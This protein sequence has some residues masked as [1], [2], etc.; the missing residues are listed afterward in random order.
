M[1]LKPRYEEGK[2]MLHLAGRFDAYQAPAVAEWLDD[3]MK[4]G[5][6]NIIIDLSGVNFIDSTGLATLVQAMKHAR[7]H[8]G[9]LVLCRLQQ[10][11]RIIFEL[12]RLDKAFR[13]F[14]TEEEALAY[15]QPVA[16]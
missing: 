15:F 9:D 7:Q 13:I 4:A 5:T 6:H 1:E 8:G 14:E 2:A 10:P 12:T 3:T 16:E 11:V